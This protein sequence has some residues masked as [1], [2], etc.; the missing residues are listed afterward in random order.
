MKP[1]AVGE[2][3]FYS[4]S[5]Q[6]RTGKIDWRLARVTE[7]RPYEDDGDIFWLAGVADPRDKRRFSAKGAYGRGWREVGVLERLADL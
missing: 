7:H 4:H 2:L 3:V 6:L 1:P 5:V